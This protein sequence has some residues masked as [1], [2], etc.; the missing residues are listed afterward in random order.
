MANQQKYNLPSANV[1]V[2]ILRANV[3]TSGAQSRKGL[4]FHNPSRQNGAAILDVYIDNAIV[5]SG[6]DLLPNEKWT[7]DVD[8]FENQIWAS[9]DT[10]NSVLI[11]I[12][13]V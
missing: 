5:G 9:S 3:K 2:L 8:T 1:P 13:D 12:E 11:V 6:V 10:N 7:Q 4:I